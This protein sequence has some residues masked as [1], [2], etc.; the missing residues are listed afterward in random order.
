MSLIDQTNTSTAK[1]REGY[2]PASF[3]EQDT[4]P[5]TEPV[6]PFQSQSGPSTL[7]AAFANLAGTSGLNTS[8]LT[9]AIQPI[10]VAL[11]PIDF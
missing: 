6:N 1:T 3:A 10:L 8:S 11:C 4:R 9:L 7:A 2:N 5:T